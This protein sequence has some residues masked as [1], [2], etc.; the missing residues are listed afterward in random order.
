MSVVDTAERIIFGPKTQAIMP[1][2]TLIGCLLGAVFLTWEAR[3]MKAEIDA[4]LKDLEVTLKHDMALARVRLLSIE[5]SLD[6]LSAATRDRYT[7]ND[8]VKDRAVIDLHFESLAK[9][10]ETLKRSLSDHQKMP[11]TGRL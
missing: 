9:E 5:K 7:S 4:S 2:A 6:L 1:M 8:A 11:H 10:V 3:G